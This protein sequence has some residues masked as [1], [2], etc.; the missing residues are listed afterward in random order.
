MDDHQ[1]R[2]VMNFLAF[3][4]KSPPVLPLSFNLPAL[5]HELPLAN[6]PDDAGRRRERY[7]EL[8]LERVRY[9][10]CAPFPLKRVCVIGGWCRGDPPRD[11][12]TLR[13]QFELESALGPAEALAVRERVIAEEEQR[14]AAAVRRAFGVVYF[15]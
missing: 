7:G 14:K 13:I 4:G 2:D 15:L 10:L 12:R 11:D 1:Y 9:G 5:Q 8:W 3:L 6:T